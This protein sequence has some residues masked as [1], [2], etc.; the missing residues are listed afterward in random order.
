METQTGKPATIIWLRMCLQLNFSS[1]IE[2]ILINKYEFA[3][4]WS[5]AY[6][7]SCPCFLASMKI[8]FNVAN[9]TA[10][11]SNAVAMFWRESRKWTKT[12]HKEGK[13]EQRNRRKFL[14]I[15][16]VI[17]SFLHYEY[18]SKAFSSSHSLYSLFYSF[19]LHLNPRSKA[20]KPEKHRRTK[21]KMCRCFFN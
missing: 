5:A 2:R 18:I 19:H 17:I 3:R 10:L 21:V 11:A 7:L 15:L 8:F 14:F 4:C 20:A 13:S 12:E 1:R 16:F 6:F 9:T